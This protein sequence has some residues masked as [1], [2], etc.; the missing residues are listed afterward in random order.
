[1]TINTD[2]NTANEN[3][4]VIIQAT[5]KCR[6]NDIPPVIILAYVYEIWQGTMAKNNII[7][8]FIII[9]HMIQLQ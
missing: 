5:Q 3:R 7:S 4:T 2:I 8:I 6:L 9:M 1:M